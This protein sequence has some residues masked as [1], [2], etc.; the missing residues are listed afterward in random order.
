MD[1]PNEYSKNSKMAF[2]QQQDSNE[3]QVEYKE[4]AVPVNAAQIQVESQPEERPD[5][6][7][8]FST[9]VILAMFVRLSSTMFFFLKE[10][11]ALNQHRL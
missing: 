2:V 4:E 7:A 1:F 9:K 10:S 8:G 6:D 3:T 5:E 11:F